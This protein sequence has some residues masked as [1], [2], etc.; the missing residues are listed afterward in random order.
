MSKQ[1]VYR[2]IFVN[3]GKVYE[4]FAREVSQGGLFGFVEVAGLLFG[5]RSAVVVDPSEERLKSEFACV[6]RFFVPMH[7]IIRIDQMDREGTA[8]V[9]DLSDKGNVT[10]FPPIYTPP[11]S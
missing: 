5:E 6:D 10:P 11:K 7:A 9:S 4:L 3:Q 8:K 1:P 2:V